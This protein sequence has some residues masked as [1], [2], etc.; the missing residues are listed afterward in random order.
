MQN[1]QNNLDLKRTHDTT[2]HFDRNYAKKNIAIDFLRNCLKRGAFYRSEFM[3]RSS[4]K[5][6]N[7]LK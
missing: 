4:N 1:A 2:M 6:H 5:H 3:T 7:Q